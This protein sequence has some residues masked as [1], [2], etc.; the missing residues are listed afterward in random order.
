MRRA[1]VCS[2]SRA[3]TRTLLAC[4]S[5]VHG[6]TINGDPQRKLYCAIARTLDSLSRCT[7]TYFGCSLAA[8]NVW[9]SVLRSARVVAFRA[10]MRRVCFNE[11]DLG[12]SSC[13]R[14]VSTG[15][16]IPRVCGQ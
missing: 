2:T 7:P 5:A 12:E 6:I 16:V 14:P 8:D 13:P 1:G 10:P 3:K 15:T 4:F 9:A 11:P